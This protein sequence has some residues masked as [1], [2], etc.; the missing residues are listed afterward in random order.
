MCVVRVC[1][2][3]YACTRVYMC[4]YVCTDA[5]AGLA[6]AGGKGEEAS[7]MCVKVALMVERGAEGADKGRWRV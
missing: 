6:L 1:I 4:V 5:R 2:C 7:V 3:V